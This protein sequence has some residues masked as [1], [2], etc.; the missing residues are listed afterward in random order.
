[1]GNEADDHPST[2]EDRA[3]IDDGAAAKGGY[4]ER[5]LPEDG[6]A[7]QARRHAAEVESSHSSPPEPTD[8]GATERDGAAGG[9]ASESGR[10]G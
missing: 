6:S 10:A 7:G 8:P 3:V 1:M 5:A 2:E 9:A 4:G